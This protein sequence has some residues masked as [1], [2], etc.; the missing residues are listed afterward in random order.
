MCSGKE[1]E[2]DVA[3]NIQSLILYFTVLYFIHAY[4]CT[5]YPIYLRMAF[6]G[7]V[8]Y[9]DGVADD[10]MEAPMYDDVMEG[11]VDAPEVMR[12]AS[13]VDTASVTVPETNSAPRTYFPE[14]W[15]WDVI[16]V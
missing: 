15:L 6:G 16:V 13:S 1:I 4:R 7:N 10:L 2:E 14:T 5:D 11:P 8:A 9:D 12:M 3:G